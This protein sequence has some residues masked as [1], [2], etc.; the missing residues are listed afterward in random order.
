MNHPCSMRFTAGRRLPVIA[1]ALLALLAGA[2]LPAQAA[3]PAKPITIP[4]VLPLT[5]HA[6]F[7][8]KEQ[9]IALDIGRKLLAEQGQPF[10][11]VY[12]DDATNSQVAVQLVS[13]LQGEG[14]R[15]MM[16]PSL[17]AGCAAVGPL[18]KSSMLDYC[19]SPTMH[20]KPGSFIFAASVDTYEI[21]QAIV[22]YAR[23]RGWKRVALITSNDAT[24]IDA[25][26]AFKEIFAE[27]ENK[28]V[29]LVANETFDPSDV[30]VNAQLVRIAAAKPDVVFAWSTGAAMATV[31]RGIVQSGIT[32]P[33]A[34]SWGNMTYAEMKAW[35]AFLPKELYFPTTPWPEH[36]RALALEPGVEAALKHLRSAFAAAGE[37][38]DAGAV[39]CWDALF[40][41]AQAYRTLGPKASPEQLRS[42]IAHLKG[43][44]GING[45]YNFVKYPQ[46]GLGIENTVVTKW[47]PARGTWKI[48]SKPTGIPLAE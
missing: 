16:G 33:V 9:K 42:Y 37:K 28:G 20:A 17:R 12:H 8:G 7:L 24:G 40:I 31:F 19:F 41:I 26:R 11:L 43:F 36:S 46:R 27:P 47:M 6:S 18:I 4:V 32:L 15:V 23:L 45:M 29:I 30:S 35:K 10:K 44:A 14:V 3:E 21:D 5:G 13:Q 39:T 22:T 38:P 34:S 25:L 1:A 48:V 2:A